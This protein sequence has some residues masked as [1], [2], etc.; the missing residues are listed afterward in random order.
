M[1]EKESEEHRG[2]ISKVESDPDIMAILNAFP[3]SKVVDVRVK[4]NIGLPEN[5][6]SEFPDDGDP[7]VELDI[8]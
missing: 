5:V 8:D 1:A 3:G 4:S 2:R 6:D 7:N